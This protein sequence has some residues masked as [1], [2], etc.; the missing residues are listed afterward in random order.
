MK[1]G[2]LISEIVKDKTKIRN[3]AICAHIDHGKTTLCDS[4]LAAGGLLSQE[5]AGRVRQLDNRE[6]E[7]ERGITIEASVVHIVY[8]QADTPYVFALLDTPGHIDFNGEVYRTMRAVDGA[9]LVVCAVEGIMPQTETVLKQLLQAKIRPILFINKIDRLIKEQQMNQTQILQR[10]AFLISQVNNLITACCSQPLAHSFAVSAQGG[11]VCF[12]SAIDSWA[13][14]VE[15]LQKEKIS[16]QQI[17]DTYHGT[18]NNEKIF[19]TQ[20]LPLADCIFGAVIKHT[21]APN[22]RQQKLYRSTELPRESDKS[23][24]TDKTLALIAD[25]NKYEPTCLFVTKIEFDQ[26]Q[27]FALC[28]LLSGTLTKGDKLICANNHESAT[29]LGIYTQYATKKEAISQIECGTC[30]LLTGLQACAGQTW[31]QIKTEPLDGF[32]HATQPVM[33][34]AVE[35]AKSMQLD[36]FVSA[37]EQLRKEDPSLHITIN[38]TTGEYLLAGLG[39]LH[40]D[41]AI[42]RIRTVKGVDVRSFTPMIVYHEMPSQMAQTPIMVDEQ[43]VGFVSIFSLRQ[44]NINTLIQ[45]HI[46]KEYTRLNTY[47]HSILKDLQIGQDRFENHNPK[48]FLHNLHLHKSHLHN[49]HLHNSH[50]EFIN[51]NLIVANDSSVVDIVTGTLKN[52]TLCLEPVCNACVLINLTISAKS[53]DPLLI[54]SAIRNCL[55][56]T[57]PVLFE[58]YLHFHIQ[59]PS[60]YVG[61]IASYLS[62]KHATISM[63]SDPLLFMILYAQLPV[64]YT[65]DMATHIRSMSQGRAVLAIEKIEYKSHAHQTKLVNSIRARKGLL[66]THI[67]E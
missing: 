30:V 43:N 23:K 64:E 44:E 24:T 29:V 8:K 14:S 6:D 57:K 2:E 21:D 47:A 39:K 32:L 62:S 58:P 15:S 5:L 51:N 54:K 49:S 48:S 40:I 34:V 10:I 12:G 53:V 55:E 35:P 52:G 56:Q 38:R 22:V 16:L 65:V 60:E 31:C 20:R 33:T 27:E 59:T 25:C 42:D 46:A 26:E 3:F 19:L 7:I 13:V 41:I 11:T 45:L 18:S 63:A 28:R 9:I 1:R 61:E 50:V 36:A 66:T 37:L 67:A 4:L 17:I